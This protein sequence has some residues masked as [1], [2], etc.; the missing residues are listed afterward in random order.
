MHTINSE[1]VLFT[2]LGDEGV[3]YHIEKNE[4]F[5]TNETFTKII[6][7]LENNLSLDQIV[8]SLMTEFEVDKETCQNSVEKALKILEEKGFIE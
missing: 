5:N 3:L 8:E 7:G 2:Q 6:L 1:K 4:Y